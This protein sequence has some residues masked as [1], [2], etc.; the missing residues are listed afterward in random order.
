MLTFGSGALSWTA[1]V[2]SIG[3][4]S[5]RTL[6]W[7]PRHLRR[8]ARRIESLRAREAGRLGRN[9]TDNEL[10]GALGV[11][12]RDFQKI[13][14]EL[15]GLEVRSIEN[16]DATGE[17]YSFKSNFS[18]TE[19]D[20]PFTHRLKSE[21]HEHLI[22]ALS[23]LPDKE[24]QVLALYYLKELTMKEVG[25]SLGV[26]ESRISQIHTSAIIHLR[27]DLVR[28]DFNKKKASSR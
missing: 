21:M 10:A 24:R 12:L 8:E 5:L 6:D 4:D 27:S 13:L 7:S 2:L 20:C 19:A 26:V 18:Y 22:E 1:Y 23:N 11:T 9:A 28:R 25:T 17:R 15:R 3:V 16:P 14:G